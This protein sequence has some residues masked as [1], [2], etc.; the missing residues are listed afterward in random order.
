MLEIKPNVH[1]IGFVDVVLRNLHDNSITIIDLK[2]STR[3][4]NKYQK[5]DQIK[6]SQ[7]LLYKKIY[8]DKYGLPMDKINVEFQILKRRLKKIGT[9]QYLVY[10]HTSWLMVNLL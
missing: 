1:F 5:R 9:S 6:N 4:W 8:S 2:T 7:I 10:Q 3:G